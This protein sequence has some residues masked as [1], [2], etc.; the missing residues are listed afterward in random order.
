MT[1]Y[2]ISNRLFVFRSGLTRPV[3]TGH[4][5]HT[6]YEMHEFGRGR[7]VNI[8]HEAVRDSADA[9]TALSPWTEHDRS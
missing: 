7:A 5:R 9:T 1:G 8:A 4:D 3:R 2:T 6:Y